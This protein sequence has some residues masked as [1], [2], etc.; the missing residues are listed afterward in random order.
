MGDREKKLEA[1]GYPLDRGPKEGPVIDL[2]S[3]VPEAAWGEPQEPTEGMPT[4]TLADDGTPSVEIPSG[5]APTDLQ[6]SVLK[7]GDGPVVKDGDTTMLQYHSVRRARM[8]SLMEQVRLM[9]Q[10]RTYSLRRAWSR[11]AT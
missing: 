6:I 11:S 9:K 8:E 5:D 2:L 4:V 3:V 10:P 7:K 1:A